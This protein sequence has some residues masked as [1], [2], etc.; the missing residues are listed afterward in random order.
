M[1]WKNGVMTTLPDKGGSGAVPNAIY[2]SG[3]DVYVVGEVNITD[4]NQTAVIGK[5]AY[6]LI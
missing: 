4:W 5:M 1:I 6:R 3:Q 2:V